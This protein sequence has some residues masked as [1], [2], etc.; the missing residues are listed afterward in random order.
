MSYQPQKIEKEVQNRWLTEQAFKV[1]AI[2]GKPKYYCLSMFPYPSGYLHVGHVRNYTISDVIARFKRMQGFN[3]LHPIGWDAF[4]LPAENAAIKHKIAPS[5][6]T[7]QNIAHMRQQLQSLG[8]FFDWSREI[9]TCHQ[10][11][12]RWEQ[13]LFTRMFEKGLV[14]RKSAMVNW[15]PV[16]DTVLANEQVIDGRGWRSGALVERREI[17]QWFFK[18][19]D[20]AEELLGALDTLD[21]WPQQVKTMQKNWIG[22]SLGLTFAFQ[23]A[24]QAEK[25]EVYTTRPDTLMGV[26]YIAIAAGHPLALR[27]AAQNPAI[28]E[29]IDSCKNL[30]TAEADLAT[31]EKRGIDS[32]L[33][34]IHPL[35][36]EK[37]PV[38]IANYVLIDY[39]S[40]AVMAVPSHDQRDFEFATLYH[41]PHKVVINEQGL[42]MNS[43]PFDGLTS[44]AAFTAI[45]D[46]LEAQGIGKRQVHYRLRDWGVSRQRYWGTPIPIIYCDTCGAVPVPDKDLPVQLPEDVVVEGKGSPLTRLDDFVNTT[47]PSCQKPAKRETDTF[48][49]FVES[50][51][52]YLRYACPQ[53]QSGLL[54]E[55]AHYWEPV[56]QYVGG[57][58]H[59]ILHLLYARFFHKVIRDMGFV[60]SNEPFTNLLTQGMVLKDGT[61]MS[62]SKGNTVDPQSLIDSYGADTVRLFTMFAAPPEQSLEWS[63]TGVEGAFRFIKKLWKMVTEHLEENPSIVAL[64][65]ETLTEAQKTIRRQLHETIA[66]ITHDM[67]KRRTFNTAIASAMSLLNTLGQYTEKAPQDA[68]LKQ[69]AY[70]AIVLM[71]SP[72]IPHVTQA[73]W[74]R[75]SQPGLIMDAAWP[76]CDESALTKATVDLVIQINGKVRARLTVPAGLANPDL[77][78]LVKN[79]DQVTKHLVDQSIQ[80][81]IIVPN[82]L[83][84][85]VCG[86]K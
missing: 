45:C 43:G 46:T 58:E 32:G 53:F 63:D 72:I 60:K 16:D 14:Y 34:V 75:L 49:T 40:G 37:I 76:I 85:I 59:A 27:A 41:L 44:E 35:T 31:L 33:Q 29:F 1:Q 48:D 38:W 57:I 68:A 6:W 56:D 23:V 5:K 30:K 18:I 11:Y 55:E 12:Y 71:L 86:G 83:V 79:H 50:S 24:D 77:E 20:Y 74:E 7:Y 52:Y 51:W 54:N 65:P 19:T 82:K 22:R 36:H 66:K 26:T 3:V 64:Q 15:D 39:G 25:V 17:S 47:C 10:D 2:P 84:N 69:E 42:L 62:K 9:A 78:N 8:L 61:K 81:I 67:D 70:T 28:A 13:W 4:G 73:L 80:K 21:G